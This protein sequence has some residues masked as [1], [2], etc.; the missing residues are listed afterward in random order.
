VIVDPRGIVTFVKRRPTA[1][2]STPLS[3]IMSRSSLV[4]I[5]WP[6]ESRSSMSSLP[7]AIGTS[8]I[9]GAATF[10]TSTVTGADVVVRPARFV[11]RAVS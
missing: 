9:T 7:L 8:R 6:S 2:W 1:L 5:T 10:S 11:A 4:A 3:T